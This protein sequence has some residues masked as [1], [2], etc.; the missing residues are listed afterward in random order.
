MS[1]ARSLGADRTITGGE[2]ELME[3]VGSLGDGLGVDV[4]IEAS[5]ASAALKPALAAVRP[6][7]QICKVGWGPQ[8]LEFSLDPLVQKA[9][10]LRGSF[11]HNFAIWEKVISLLAFGKLDPTLIVG[12]MEPL[13]GWRA[14]FEEMGEGKIAKAV[15]R[16]E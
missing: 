5:G 16:P 9:V 8:P 4:V 14:C 3:V 7:G 13:A 6:S 12:R 1:I 10:Q 2:Q 11:S 15:L